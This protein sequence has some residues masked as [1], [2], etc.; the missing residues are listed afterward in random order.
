MVFIRPS[1]AGFDRPLTESCPSGFAGVAQEPTGQGDPVHSGPV[2]GVGAVSRRWKVR[3]RHEPGG[4][5]D[6]AKLR[7]ETELALHWPPGRRLAERGDLQPADYRPPVSVG[8]GG[9]AVRCVASDPDLHP[10]QPARV[11]TLELE[12]EGCLTVEVG[13]KEVTGGCPSKTRNHHTSHRRG[14]HGVH[15]TDNLKWLA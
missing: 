5:R 10:D 3:D 8:P 1:L 13:W 2:G 12:A 7:R 15:H 6:P 14:N 11:A 9:L 4:E